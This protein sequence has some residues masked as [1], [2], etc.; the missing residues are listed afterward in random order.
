MVE[1][2]RIEQLLGVVTDW[3]RQRPDIRGVALVGSWARDTARPDSDVDLVMLT[4]RPDHY[5]ARADW[6]IPLGATQIV[7]TQPWGPLTERRLLLDGGLEVEVGVAQ[8]TWAATNPV[9]AGTRRVVTDGMRILYDPDQRLAALANAC[10]SAAQGLPIRWRRGDR[11]GRS[12]G[13]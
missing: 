13:P 8:P 11:S 1:R 7:R 12:R 6:A 5:T 10:Q 4:T 9:D 2:T 3:A